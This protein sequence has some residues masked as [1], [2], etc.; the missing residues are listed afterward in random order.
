MA[1]DLQISISQQ[2]G[3][4]PVTVFHIQSDMIDAHTYQQFEAQ[5]QAAFETGTRNLLLDLTKVKYMSSAGLRA[6]HTTFML[7]RADTPAESNELMKKGLLDGSFKSP[8][9]K[10]LNPSPTVM[11]TLRAMGF[12]MFLEI[13][14]NLE[15]A[16]ASF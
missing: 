9:L 6:L 14:H 10:L 3:R 13:H 16:I 5:V 15:D 7:L 4:I 8:H 1:S 2:Q 11:E 12:D